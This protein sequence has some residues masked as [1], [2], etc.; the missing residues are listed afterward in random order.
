[1]NAIEDD[2]STMAENAEAISQTLEEINSNLTLGVE[3]SEATI[4]QLNEQAQEIAANS[5]ALQEQS[6]EMVT[7]IKSEIQTRGESMTNIPPNQS[8]TDLKSALSMTKEY[9]T[10]IKNSMTDGKLTGM[11]LDTIAQ[12]GANASA[13]LELFGGSQFQGFASSIPDITSKFARGE[14]PQAQL[15]FANFE[16]SLPSFPGLRD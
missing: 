13:G 1:M 11:E 9:M 16:N 4:S 7:Q 5:Q 10:S 15:S 14:L 3:L 8:A 2:L 6:Q 12:L